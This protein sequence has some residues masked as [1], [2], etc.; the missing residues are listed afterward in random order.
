MTEQDNTPKAITWLEWLDTQEDWLEEHRFSTLEERVAAQENFIHNL[1]HVGV[2]PEIFAFEKKDGVFTV[3]LQRHV[4]EYWE[5]IQSRALEASRIAQI[6]QA[7]QELAQRLG[8][9]AE[10]IVLDLPRD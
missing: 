2:D 7:K 4:P 10:L 5:A 8:V 6:Q 1:Q 9:N 3:R